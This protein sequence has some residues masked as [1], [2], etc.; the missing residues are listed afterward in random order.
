MMDNPFERR[1]TEYLRDEEA[2]LSVIAPEPMR[3]HIVSARE[4]LYDRLVILSGTPGSGKSTLARLFE[5][6][7]LLAVLRHSKVHAALATVLEDC[8]ALHDRAP[9]VL[10]G[11][12]P[13]ET[14]YRDIWEFPYAEEVRHNLLNALIQARAVLVWTRQLRRAEV[15]DSDFEAIPGQSGPAAF[16]AVGGA[17]LSQFEARA[18]AVEREIYSI[19]GA[20][21]PPPEDKLRDFE[22]SHSY[23]PFEAISEFRVKLPSLPTNK[24]ISLQPMVMLDDAH[25]LHPVQLAALQ[26]WLIRRELRLARWMLSRL[27][28]EPTED[29]LALTQRVDREAELPGI[30]RAREITIISLQGNDRNLFRRMARD[31]ANRY[32]RLMPQFLNRKLD[33][34]SVML[35]EVPEPLGATK[36]KSLAAKVDSAQRRLG[37]SD[38]RRG[39]L[40]EQVQAYTPGGRVLHADEQHAMLLILMHRYA[41]RVPQESL[42]GVDAG[43]EPSKPLVADSTVYQG[44]RIHLLHQYDKAF[45]YGMDDLCDASSENAEQFLRLAARLVDALLARMVRPQAVVALGPEIQHELLRERAHDF[46]RSWNFP[47][48]DRVLKLVSHI[49]DRCLAESLSPNAWLGGGANAYGIPQ[50][51][52]EGIVRTHPD[53]ANTLKFGLAYKAIS[54]AQDYPCKNKAWCLIQLGGLPILHFGLTLRKGGFVEGNVVELQGAIET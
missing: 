35:N 25:V 46:V 8:G 11:R 37:I 33:N 7:A 38:R 3:A 53:L 34:F 48:Y 41:N 51:D 24:A 14:D 18:Q 26:R 47:H 52:F 44:A 23:R 30:T 17:T 54:L 15:G 4:K 5:F 27:D 22:A 29:V 43:P 32:L 36:T 42:F 49:A 40:Q 1:A 28:V 12:L 13:L 16:E 21:L 6:P 19:V 39:E 10:A 50:V 45:F 9:T 20:L 31:M 2:F